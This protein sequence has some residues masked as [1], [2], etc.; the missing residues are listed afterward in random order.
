MVLSKGNYME[1]EKIYYTKIIFDCFGLRDNWSILFN[2][3]SKEAAFESREWSGGKEKVVENFSVKLTDEDIAQILPYI[4]ALDFEP[5]RY[6]DDSE[7]FIV[8]DAPVVKFIGI[9]NSYLPLYKHGIYFNDN[10]K[11]KRPYE[12]LFL[13]IVEK[14]FSS[15][16]GKYF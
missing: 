3:V 11:E 16:I 7:D 9:T 15:F 12:K 2:V 8:Y 13:Y 14:Y 6:V 5:Y 1:E 10:R 4:N